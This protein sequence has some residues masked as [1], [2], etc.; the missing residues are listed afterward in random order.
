MKNFIVFSL[1]VFLILNTGQSSSEFYFPKESLGD[2]DSWNDGGVGKKSES[3]SSSSFSSSSSSSSFTSSGSSSSSDSFHEKVEVYEKNT[4][5][6]GTHEV[7]KIRERKKPTGG[8]E[9]SSSKV[10]E[11]FRYPNGTIRRKVKNNGPAMK[12]ECTK[13]DD[14]TADK[15]CSKLSYQCQ[16]CLDGFGCFN[17]DQ[18]CGKKVCK[19]GQCADEPEH[20][21]LANSP[22]DYD[23]QCKSGLFCSVRVFEG[24]KCEDVRTEGQSCSRGIFSRNPPRC[25]E[26]L[27]CRRTGGFPFSSYKCLKEGSVEDKSTKSSFDSFHDNDFFPFKK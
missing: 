25:A 12:A 16:Q 3:S 19:F 24:G 8:N 9:T 27:E 18:C 26:G 23:S 21:G 6:K 2:V 5:E 15:F 13:N 4:D 17:D 1:S 10:I 20:T 11:V 14:C 22:C 7:T